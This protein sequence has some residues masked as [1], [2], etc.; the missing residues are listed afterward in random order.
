MVK[1][2]DYIIDMGLKAKGKGGA[3]HCDRIS[4]KAGKRVLQKR[5]PYGRISCKRVKADA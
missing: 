1:N 5:E 2:A 4:R 3:C